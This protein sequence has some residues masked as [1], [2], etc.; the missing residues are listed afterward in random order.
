MNDKEKQ[1]LCVI[2]GLD[3]E[4]VEGDYKEALQQIRKMF[5]DAFEDSKNEDPE[6]WFK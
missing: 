6:R 3:P 2:L 1:E 4:T 5:E